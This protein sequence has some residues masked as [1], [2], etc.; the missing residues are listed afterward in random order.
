MSICRFPIQPMSRPFVSACRSRKWRPAA[1]VQARLDD[2]RIVNHDGARIDSSCGHLHQPWHERRAHPRQPRRRESP[3]PS[4]PPG[5]NLAR[6]A[7]QATS[8]NRRRSTTSSESCKW[9]QTASS[10]TRRRASSAGTRQ[11]RRGARFCRWWAR[12]LGGCR[13]RFFR[14]SDQGRFSLERDRAKIWISLLLLLAPTKPGQNLREKRLDFI[15]EEFEV[16]FSADGQ[17]LEQRQTM[18]P[19]FR[20]DGYLPDGLHPAGEPEVMFRFGSST[21]RRRRSR[22]SASSLD[23]IGKTHRQQANCWSMEVLSRIKS[24]RTTSTR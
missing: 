8:T 18:I 10:T 7:R 22:A 23:R 2:I 12:S 24:S 20:E 15:P 19:Q 9:R 13:N 21:P 3:S 6:R 14:N 1:L 16:H 17:E 4:D 11:S 5:R